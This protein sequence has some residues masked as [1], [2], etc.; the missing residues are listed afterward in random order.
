[1]FSY[2]GEHKASWR[3][4]Y[5]Q[6][7]WTHWESIDNFFYIYILKLNTHCTITMTT[8]SLYEFHEPSKHCNALWWK[9]TGL[10]KLERKKDDLWFFI[11]KWEAIAPRQLGDL[12]SNHTQASFASRAS[13]SLESSALDV[14]SELMRVFRRW[15]GRTIMIRSNSKAEDGIH[16]FAWVYESVKIDCIS[17]E[18]FLD[19]IRTVVAS[20]D[21]PHARSYRSKNKVY[22]D[23]MGIIIQ[24]FVEWIDWWYGV[25]HTS[26][27][28]VDYTMSI[29]GGDHE[30]VTDKKGATW[31]TEVPKNCDNY[32]AHNIPKWVVNSLLSLRNIAREVEKLYGKSDIEYVIGKD[33]KIYL[34]QLRSLNIPE[35]TP[36]IDWVETITHLH[37]WCPAYFV[38]LPVLVVESLENLAVQWIKNPLN[39]LEFRWFHD[40]IGLSDD[41]WNTCRSISRQGIMNALHRIDPNLKNQPLWDWWDTVAEFNKNHPNWFVLS[42][43]NGLPQGFGWLSRSLWWV[44]EAVEN[45]LFSN[46][47]A[48]IV[49]AFQSTHSDGLAHA[50]IRAREEAVPV[51]SIVDNPWLG[52]NLTELHTWDILSVRRW[53]LV[54]DKKIEDIAI[55]TLTEHFPWIH[56]RDSGEWEYEI[57]FPGIEV[58]LDVFY[59][60]L[61]QW[62]TQKKWASYS[63]QA[64]WGI[65]WCN[66]I[67]G[68]H[69]IELR[70]YRQYPQYWSLIINQEFHW[71]GLKEFLDKHHNLKIKNERFPEDTEEDI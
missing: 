51:I 56:I 64:L 8:H 70:G 10:Q 32:L 71:S 45:T 61:A 9:A 69:C 58:Q 29:S 37:D 6:N 62:L 48:L 43:P 19:A 21:S 63:K 7:M 68:D 42:I 24:E 34:L 23:T 66:F 1:M 11:P 28:Q 2:S 31:R 38:W 35:V 16:T 20:L 30:G 53:Q 33:G 46:M 41:V 54:R 49:T 25:I 57:I 39:I 18:V 26:L 47:K 44:K 12:L 13:N 5:E 27:P 15:E 4:K 22:S 14:G 3:G 65:V 67:S 52:T 17:F 59:N 50:D 55:S 60:F 40:A 36:M